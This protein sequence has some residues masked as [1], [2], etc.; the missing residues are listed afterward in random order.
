MKDQIKSIDSQLIELRS[1]AAKVNNDLCGKAFSSPEEKRKAKREYMS[2]A[3]Q[4]ADLKSEKHKLSQAIAAANSAQPEGA[5]T[6]KV[7][8]TSLYFPKQGKVQYFATELEFYELLLMLSE[9]FED[10]IPAVSS[11]FAVPNNAVQT[12]PDSWYDLEASVADE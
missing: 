10:D 4:I 12:I 3:S 6:P 1:Q 8:V 2:L 5:P 9:V 11:F 7:K